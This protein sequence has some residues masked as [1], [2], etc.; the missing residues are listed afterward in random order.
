MNK[1]E[2]N[3]SD[4]TE[5]RPLRSPAEWITFGIS[6]VILASL[7]S[8]IGYTWIERNRQEQDPVLSVIS[9][10]NSIR[11]VNGQFYIPF[12]VTNDGAETAE[13]VQVLAE[14]E[15]KGKVVE[16]GEQQVDFLS[17]GEREEGAF[18][19]SRNPRS[20]KL[21]IRIASYKKS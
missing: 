1:N 7:I 19:F 4:N 16:S 20:G 6:L 11:E 3:F 13:S 18:I 14:L 5:E 2:A 17:K 21:T 10:K 15:I 8:A 12:E 9:N